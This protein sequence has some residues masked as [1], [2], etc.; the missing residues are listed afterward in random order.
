MSVIV[1]TGAANGMGRA[2]VDRLRGRADE[3][4]AVDLTA[5]DLEGAVG[6]ACDVSDPAAVDRLAADVRGR[7]AFRGLVHAA[8]ISPTMGDVRRVFEVDLVGTQLLLDAFE[9]LVEPGSAAVCF[10]SSSAYQVSMMGPDPELDAFVED[11][12]PTG[13]STGPPSASTTAASH[14]VGPSAA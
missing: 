2:S 11:P 12:A 9:P 6:V 1:V 3:I 7:G 8:G 14:T 5:P 4:V 13:S 10:A